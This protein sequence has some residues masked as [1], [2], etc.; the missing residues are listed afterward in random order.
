MKH[1]AMNLTRTIVASLALVAPIASVA[2][3]DFY[4][5]DPDGRS[6][7]ASSGPSETGPIVFEDARL[8]FSQG[9]YGGMFG[10]FKLSQGFVMQGV[11]ME[12]RDGISQGSSGTLLARVMANNV[13]TTP[14]GTSGVFE[15]KGTTQFFN[16]L[17]NPQAIYY[18][19]M[20]VIGVGT[21]ELVTTSGVNGRGL[22]LANGNS[23]FHDP[24]NAL[25]YTDT[26]NVLGAGTWD[27]SIGMI[28]TFIPEPGTFAVLGAGL[29]FLVIRRVRR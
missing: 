12:I 4:G 18:I 23:F 5:G 11:E 17:P 20:R 16:S 29:G 10:H 14:T 21:A 25:T 2:D 13:F 7:L 15:V 22:P 6:W 24:L 3:H 26:Q 8:G 28:D 1:Y 9:L 27:F 19:G